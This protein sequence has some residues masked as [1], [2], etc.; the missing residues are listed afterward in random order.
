M[1]RSD[2]KS[3]AMGKLLARQIVLGTVALI[4]TGCASSPYTRGGNPQGL[5]QRDVERDYMECEY[6][7]RF[8]NPQ[9][10]YNQG[11]PFPFTL[12][13]ESIQPKKSKILP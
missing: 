13:R 4:L 7:A 8:A 6:K 10:F 3:I 2:G 1:V 9:Q 12:N 5:S 11:S